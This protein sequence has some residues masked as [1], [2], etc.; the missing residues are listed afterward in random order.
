MRR[1]GVEPAPP[2][3]QAAPFSEMMTRL[4]GGGGR[5][6]MCALEASP[7]PSAAEAAGSSVA[8]SRSLSCR[9]TGVSGLVFRVLRKGI[10]D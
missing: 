9:R 7:P 3:P 8:F 4:Q 6:R 10:R 2:H 5:K 1:T